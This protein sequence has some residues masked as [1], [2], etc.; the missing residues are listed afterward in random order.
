MRPV[1]FPVLQIYFVIHQDDKRHYIFKN[2]VLRFSISPD[3]SGRGHSFLLFIMKSGE[4]I[5]F[6]VSEN[7]AREFE[8][9]LPHPKHVNAIASEGEIEDSIPSV[10]SDR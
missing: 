7:E 9:C 3:R 10:D 6:P 8:S 5:G 4:R 1:R 2:N